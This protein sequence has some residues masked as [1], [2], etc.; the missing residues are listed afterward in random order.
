[1]G[2]R[3]GDIWFDVDALWSREVP[4]EEP[5]TL[6]ANA[7]AFVALDAAAL[8]ADVSSGLAESRQRRAERRRRR[9]ARRRQTAAAVI[10]PAMLLGLVSPRLGNA[11]RAQPLPQDPPS[12]ASAILDT[13]VAAP[14]RKAKQEVGESSPPAIRWNHATSHGLPYAGWLSGGTQ[15]PLEGPDW[16]TW[17]PVADRVPNRPE[18]LFGNERLIR[19]LLAVAAAHRAGDPRGPRIVVGEISFRGGG[20]M[21][22]HRSHQNG[23]DVDVYYP[24][25]DAR[26]RPPT[27]EDQIDRERAQDLVDR[28]VALGVEKIFVGYA[29]DLRG[30]SE[31]VTPYP[32]HE[33]HMHVR[34]RG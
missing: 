9:N 17:N 5:P 8:G 29:T 15:L 16:V 7:P 10:G 11:S 20:P 25:R 26:L 13:I 18:R 31:V 27:E 14:V 21:E 34:L 6:E 1:M 30:P 28:F 24:R 12:A 19:Q 2:W 23:L 3:R 22:L 4:D 32:N 33:D